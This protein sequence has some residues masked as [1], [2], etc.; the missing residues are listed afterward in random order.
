MALIRKKVK[1]VEGSESVSP[2]LHPNLIAFKQHGFTPQVPAGGDHVIG[3]C[4]FCSSEGHAQGKFYVNTESKKWDCKHCGKSGGYQTFLRDM[5]QHCIEST[6][7][8]VV[9]RLAD[10]RGLRPSTLRAHDI[11]WNP[12]TESFTVPIWDGEH[13]NILDIK[14]YKNKKLMSTAGCNVGIF[15][16]GDLVRAGNDIER[17]WLVE[18]E[19]DRMAMWE[20]LTRLEIVNEVVVSVPGAGTFKPEWTGIFHGKHTVVVYDNDHDRTLQNGK[21]V[22]GAGKMGSIKVYNMLK[23][24]TPKIEF[25]HWNEALASGY[26]L[27]DYYKSKNLSPRR[28]YSSLQR[29]LQSLPKDYETTSAGKAELPPSQKYTGAGCDIEEVYKVFNQYLLLL[30]NDVITV[31]FATIIAN[32]LPGDPLW[33]FIVGPSG[34]GKSEVIMALN[35]HKFI[36]P[37]SSLT[38]HTLLSGA[39]FS[40]ENDP[41]LIPKLNGKILTIKD[42]TTILGMNVTAQAE[43]IS[44]LRDAYDGECAKPF[45]NGRFV[46]YTSKFGIIA[47]VTGMIDVFS[48][49][50]VALG[51]RFIKFVIPVD[52]TLA[53]ERAVLHRVASNLLNGT[54]DG[55][56][57]DL[58][59]ITNTFLDFD[60]G[61]APTVPDHIAHKVISLA[62]WAGMMRGSVIRDQRTMEIAYKPMAEYCTRLTGQFIKMVQG[63]G[64]VRKLKEV[65]DEEYRIIKY[66]AVGTAPVREEEMVRKIYK[67]EKSAH[68]AMSKLTEILGLPSMTAKKITENLH[69][70]GVLKKHR[71]DKIDKDGNRVL[72]SLEPRYIALLEDAEIYNDEKKG[73]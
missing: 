53:G 9:K 5:A 43:I 18:G 44:Q 48:E 1:K 60:F 26:D 31:T 51:E 64:M 22:M 27:R 3:L 42:F 8:Q 38:P 71:L 11:G 23:G 68:F 57:K 49:G 67:M 32:R 16:V 28:T 70:L 59:T 62:Q 33:L 46:K 7:P 61:D 30:N 65:T 17:V 73:K 21:T 55:M 4:P 6:T 2:L 41:S 37:I 47:G 15:G 35:E 69:V 72:W 20:I 14:I 29:L 24:V 34:S 50:L 40:A 45:G 52:R 39:N 13:E 58:R 25:A 36:E 12:L 54:K 19:W 66:I 10:D 56:Q 63:L